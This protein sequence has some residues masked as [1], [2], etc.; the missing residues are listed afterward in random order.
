MTE[1]IPEQSAKMWG[2]IL[3][4]TIFWE[5]VTA[6]ENQNLLE[7]DTRARKLDPKRLKK[8]RR[9]MTTAK[10]ALSVWEYKSYPRRIKYCRYQIEKLK[11]TDSEKLVIWE[12]ALKELQ[13]NPPDKPQIGFRQRFLSRWFVRFK[14]P[15]IRSEKIAQKIRLQLDYAQK[16]ILEH[17]TAIKNEALYEELAYE[18][19]LEVG[20]FGQQLVQRWSALANREEFYKDGKRHIRKVQIEECHYTPDEIQYKIKV[21]SR[22]L[23]GA[24]RHHLP[25]RV[26]AWNLV[27]PETLSELSAACER[28]VSTPHDENTPESFENGAWIVVYREGLTDGLFDFVEYERVISKYDPEKHY[29]F[30]IPLGVKRGR[31]VQWLYLSEHPH[32]MV[33]G[34]PGSGKTNAIRG[35]LTTLCEYHSPNEVRFFIVDLKRGGDF[36]EYSLSPHLASPIITKISDLVDIVPRLVALMQKRMDMMFNI[37]VRDIDDY[38]NHVDIDAQMPRIVIVID[39]CNSIDNLASSKADRDVIWRGLTLI[40]TQ[41]RAA[42][43]HLLLGTQ[44]SFSDSIP[45]SVRDNITFVLSGR[46]RTLAG[47]LATFGRGV[48]KSLPNI[49]GRMWCDDGGELFQLQTPYVSKERVYESVQISINF[50]EF[51]PLILPELDE[52]EIEGMRGNSVFTYE[53]VARI[54]IEELEGVM[55]QHRIH[56][57]DYVPDDVSRRD[58][59]SMI[60]QIVGIGSIEYDGNLY[61]VEPYRKGYQLVHNAKIPEYQDS[62]IGIMNGSLNGNLNTTNNN[63][64][65]T[66]ATQ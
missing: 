56:A 60:Q 16:R 34:I 47:S 40:A 64:N 3:P 61:T 23:L 21:S 32:L 14:I 7:G 53:D 29:R 27:R 62:D 22:T 6:P 46:Q 35:V 51:D 8:L 48:A 20:Y 41:A 26:T 39:E 24:V 33:N 25:D 11:G 15:I 13:L 65:E 63:S 54:A 50:G 55:S 44:Q 38:N 18:M 10:Q 2:D 12:A 42:G 30:P 19:Q 45:K 66:E 57:M 58:I 52:V 31:I 28:P 5:D 37:N 1:Q 49:H 36:R 43:I 4:G 9:K 59:A 17:E